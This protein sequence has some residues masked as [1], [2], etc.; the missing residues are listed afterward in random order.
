MEKRTIERRELPVTVDIEQRDEH[1]PVIKGHAAVFNKWANVYGFKERI[2]PGAFDRAIKEDDVRALFNHDPNYVLGRTASGTLRLSVDNRGLVYEIDP[3][4]TQWADDLVES[5][6]RGD[7]SQSSFGFIVTKES[8]EFK[9]DGKMDERTIEEVELFDVSPVTYPAY[10][11]TD[12]KVRSAEQ[13][14]AEARAAWEAKALPKTITEETTPE[15]ATQTETL[16]Q[17]PVG[18]QALLD[19]ALSGE[20][21]ALLAKRRAK[22]KE[23]GTLIFLKEMQYE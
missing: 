19:G 13:V 2:V 3:P 7:I 4:D 16:E 1:T 18:T 15:T 23:Q 12:V 17:E 22:L 5:M 20:S 8:W 6:R 14:H 11:Q 21:Q 10:P 9:G